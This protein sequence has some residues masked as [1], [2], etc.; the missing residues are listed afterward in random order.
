MNYFQSR[1]GPADMAKIM[2]P[3]ILEVLEAEPSSARRRRNLE[4]S[5]AAFGSDVRDQAIFNCMDA[6]KD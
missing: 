6:S 5:L 3:L 4:I 2:Y 1:Q